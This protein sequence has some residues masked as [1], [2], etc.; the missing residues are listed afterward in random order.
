M[1]GD[2]RL[3]DTKP[4]H[5]CVLSLLLPLITDDDDDRNRDQHLLFSS[6]IAAGYFDACETMA[7]R[8]S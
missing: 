7:A 1:S 5:V 8:H 3:M 2:I 6:S 4:W